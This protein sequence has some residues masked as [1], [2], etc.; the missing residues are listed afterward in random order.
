MKPKKGKFKPLNP[1]KYKGNPT[2]IVYRSGLELKLMLRFDKDPQILEWSSEEITIPY[3]CKTDNRIH[4]YF[5]DFLIK[6]KKS[7]GSIETILIEVKPYSQTIPPK[8]GNKKQKTF[9]NEVMT[10]AKNDSKWEYAKEY[11]NKKGWSF[12]IITEREING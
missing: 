10:Y 6:L 3:Q 8:K 7:N 5:P 4:R 12:R 11:C 9:I 2:T 1:E